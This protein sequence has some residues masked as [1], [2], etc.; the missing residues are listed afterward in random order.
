MTLLYDKIQKELRGEPTGFEKLL[1]TKEEHLRQIVSL[2]KKNPNITRAELAQ[3]VGI[4]LRT[5]TRHLQ[6]LRKI[7]AVPEYVSFDTKAHTAKF[8]KFKKLLETRPEM[9]R[10]QLCLEVG[11]SRKTMYRYLAELRKNDDKADERKSNE[12]K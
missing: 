8:A 12:P 9:S 5:V 7:K 1:V 3:A 4:S 10:K 11:I 2:V 6:D